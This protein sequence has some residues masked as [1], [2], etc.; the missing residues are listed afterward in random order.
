MSASN[1]NFQH[2]YKELDEIFYSHVNPVPVA[3]PEMVIINENLAHSLNLDFSNLSGPEQAELFSEMFCQ[4][5]RHP[6]HK[7]MQAINSAISLSSVMVGLTFWE[8]T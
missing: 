4:R 7:L 5:A 8:S 6:S 1:F 3:K 2:S